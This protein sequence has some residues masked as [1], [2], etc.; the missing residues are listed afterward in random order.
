MYLTQLDPAFLA[1]ESDSTP[2]LDLFFSAT[3]ALDSR[4]TFVR[5]ST[6]TF[7][8]SAGLVETASSGAARFTH[9]PVTLASLGLLVEESRANLVRYSQEFDNSYWIKQTGVTV[10]QA[11]EAADPAGGTSADRV[12]GFNSG[13]GDRLQSSSVTAT[14]STAYSGSVWIRGEGVNIGRKLIFSAKRISGATFAGAETEVTL[15]DQWQRVSVVFTSAADTLTIGLFFNAGIGSGTLASSFLVWG[16]Q[17]EAGAFATSYI[18]TDGTIGGKTRAA[19]VVTMTGT[20]FSS[21]YNQTE[22]TLALNARLDRGLGGSGRAAVSID[23]GL[24]NRITIGNT[25]ADGVCNF[26]V[27]SG[28]ASQYSPTLS[29]I[30]TSGLTRGAALAYISGATRGAANGTLASAG[31]GSLPIGVNQLTIGAT[32]TSTITW[33]G[34]ISRI[35]YYR[36]RLPDASLQSL[37]T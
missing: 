37:T 21:W 30:W 7:I 20:N 17:L 16:A 27:V 19:D 26:A 1:V 18:P 24:S 2:S 5:A 11:N 23:N 35:R 22:G 8:N 13:S 12:N 6:G 32:A 29:N 14:A 28:G 4:I 34:T 3:K 10:E 33:C 9:D 25:S 31:T 15:T 36:R